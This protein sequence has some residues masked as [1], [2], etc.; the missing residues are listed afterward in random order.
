[1]SQSSYSSECETTVIFNIF[2]ASA[3]KTLPLQ[4]RSNT[5]AKLKIAIARFAN[6][7]Y[8]R[9]VIAFVDRSRSVSDTV[10]HRKGISST[11]TT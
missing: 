9:L 6:A 2:I 1:M 4:T 7:H 5:S 8:A 10:T 3:P 11:E